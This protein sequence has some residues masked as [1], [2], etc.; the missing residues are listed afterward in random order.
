MNK[1]VFKT[2]SCIACLSAA[3]LT[4][5]FA[6]TRPV[7][8]PRFQIK[9]P[10]ITAPGQRVRCRVESVITTA[11]GAVL[12]CAG[13]NGNVALL[14]MGDDSMELGLAMM[15]DNTKPYRTFVIDKPKAT[16]LQSCKQ[17]GRVAGN[18]P[19]FQVLVARMSLK[20]SPINVGSANP[21]N[22]GPNIPTQDA[23]PDW[24]NIPTQDA[25]PDAGPNIPTQDAR[26]D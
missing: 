9:S 22:S 5:A 25:N 17:A 13:Q 4:L 24:P 8:Q 16:S 15:S 14:A 2:A 20:D 19:C 18:K 1:L 23:D 7:D 6:Q 21:D 26:P 12:E 3:S 10:E 11:Q